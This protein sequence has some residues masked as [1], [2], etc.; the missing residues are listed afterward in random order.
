M[1]AIASETFSVLRGSSTNAWGDETDA[2]TVVLTGVP[3]ALQPAG[4][5][6]TSRADGN[7]REV[8]TFA[9]RAPYGTDLRLDDRIKGETSG[10]VYVLAVVAQP[11]DPIAQGDLRLECRRVAGAT[12]TSGAPSTMATIAAA[13]DKLTAP[14]PSGRANIVVIGDSNGEGQGAVVETKRW[15]A[16]LQDRLRAAADITG[17]PVAFLP[18]AYGG[19]AL[20]PAPSV[21]DLSNSGASTT[22]DVRYGLGARARQY[23]RGAFS[24]WT[25]TFTSFK[26]H[27]AKDT[28]GVNANVTVDGVA[29]APFSCNGSA[30]GGFTASYGPFAE[31]QHTVKVQCSDLA[32]GFIVTL[33]GA[34]FLQGDETVGLSV[35][36]GSKFGTVTDSFGAEHAKSVASL[37]PTAL[38]FAQG[39]NDTLIYTAA[40]SQAKMSA[41]I[42]TTSA[43]ASASSPS[44]IVLIHPGRADAILEPYAN[45]VAGWKAAA[46]ANGAAVIDLSNA[47]LPAGSPSSAALFADNVHYSQAGH[48]LVGETVSGVLLAR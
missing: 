16:V 44:K 7:L 47:I 26:I 30:A 17:A 11:L 35:Y 36:D 31:G 34:S 37:S 38:I 24:T 45:Y 39:I 1:F 9:G 41:L 12:T 46:S 5:G 27:Y 23:S 43:A 22:L 14:V 6:R 18:P 48:E 10:N 8:D 42:A 15:I 29:Q 3:I 20:S 2:S 25:T 4:R 40:Q 13:L 32:S 28:F 33:E 19:T 21:I